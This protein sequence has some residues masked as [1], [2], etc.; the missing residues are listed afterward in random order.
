MSQ[1]PESPS[2]AS[3]TSPRVNPIP[4]TVGTS[5]QAG[6]VERREQVVTDASGA[7]HREKVVHNVAAEQQNNLQVITRAVWLIIGVIEILIGLRVILKLIAA[8]PDNAFANF[9]Y[10]SASLFLAPFFGLT[11]SP[12]GNGMVLEIPSLIAMLVYAGIG[13]ILVRVVQM[14]MDR[15]STRSTSTYDRFRG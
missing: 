13:W 12:A 6:G 15:P 10:G 14:F 9:I 4:T 3:P 2:T 7:E 11:G 8:N 5:T 1:A